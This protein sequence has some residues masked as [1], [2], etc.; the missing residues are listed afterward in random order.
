MTEREKQLRAALLWARN[1]IDCGDPTL[2]ERVVERLDKILDDGEPI[3]GA[4]MRALAQAYPLSRW[5]PHFPYHAYPVQ[6]CTHRIWG[7]GRYAIY[8][9]ETCSGRV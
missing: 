5:E 2:K 1:H 3:I 8:P 7:L 9:V 6:P 4:D